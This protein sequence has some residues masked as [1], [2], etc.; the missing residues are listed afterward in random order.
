MKVFH[1]T[2]LVAGI[3]LAGSGCQSDKTEII[4]EKVK[5]RV[6]EFVKTKREECRVS[7]ME[8]AEKVVD[9]LLLQEAQY[10]LRDSLNRTKPSAPFPPSEVPPIDSLEIKP[11][12]EKN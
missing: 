1:A 5:A 12:F 2:A 3:V 9:S 8:E 4:A 10:G 7:L 6:D 11:I